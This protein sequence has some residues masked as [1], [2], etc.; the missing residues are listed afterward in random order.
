MMTGSAPPGLKRPASWKPIFLVSMSKSRTVSCSSDTNS[1]SKE[2]R[3][4]LL[5]ED[6]LDL[7]DVQR[8]ELDQLIPRPE[9]PLE[10]LLERGQDP[11]Q[12]AL[13]RL[14]GPHVG[15]ALYRR[16]DVVEGKSGLVLLRVAGYVVSFSRCRKRVKCWTRSFFC[17]FALSRYRMYRA[18]PFGE[19]A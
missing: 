16:P 14:L 19:R 10:L 2:D 3:V 15:D 4:Q 6:L 1:G 7:L 13:T 11:V 8:A 17:P 5:R 12:R 18:R 9:A